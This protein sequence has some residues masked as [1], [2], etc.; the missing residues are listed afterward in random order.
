MSQLLLLGPILSTILPLVR[1]RQRLPVPGKM[2]VEI[3]NSKLIPSTSRK[4]HHPPALLWL[5]EEGLPAVK[6]L[7]AT[8]AEEEEEEMV[9]IALEIWKKMNEEEKALW[10]K[11]AWEVECGINRKI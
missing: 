4:G 11:K 6:E 3:N 1:L 2:E 10:R 7:L 5:E 8:G 9:R